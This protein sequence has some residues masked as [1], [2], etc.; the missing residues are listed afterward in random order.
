MESPGSPS[1]FGNFNPAITGG[2]PGVLF[3]KR[4]RNIFKGPML[5]LGGGR[6]SRSTGSGSANHSRSASASG[7]GRK[8]G[9]MAIQEE[10]EDAVEDTEGE[11]EGADGEDIE[12]V[13]CFSPIVKGPGEVVE[14]KIFEEGETA[15]VDTG[16]GRST[17]AK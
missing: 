2:G 11:A 16:Q 8:S 17:G 12:E 7:L 1:R 10:D 9:E 5:S 4:K 6:D 15:E 3:A 13:D 14:E